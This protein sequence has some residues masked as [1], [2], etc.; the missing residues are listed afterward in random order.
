MIATVDRCSFDPEVNIVILSTAPFIAAGIG[1]SFFGYVRYV[2][3]SGVPLGAQH[4]E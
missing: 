2:K 3:P 1:I 4:S